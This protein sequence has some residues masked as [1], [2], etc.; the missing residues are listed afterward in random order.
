MAEISVGPP[1]DESEL[2][3]VANQRQRT[4]NQTPEQADDWVND[5]LSE[6]GNVRVVRKDGAVAGG[7]NL[8]PMGQWFGGRSVPMA[9]IGGVGIDP[10]HRAGGLASILM[11]SVVEELQTSGCALS[12]L[13]P[14]TVP[15]YRRVGYE[16]SGSFSRYSIRTN[17]I[18]IRERELD[19]TFVETPDAEMLA[20]LYTKRARLTS[21]NL[22]R[23]P[24]FWERV[25]NPPKTTLHTYVF[26]DEGYVT[27]T[28]PSGDGWGYD[29]ALRDIV[30]LT[31]RAARR[32]WTFFADHR[33]FTEKV[34]WVGTQADPLVFHLRE[35][36]WKL[37]DDWTWMLR[38]ID[39]ERALTERGYSGELE[40]EVSFE[41]ADDLLPA[42]NG[43]FTLH[44]SGGKGE[45][46]RNGNARTKLDVRGLASLYTGF[47][48]AETLR[49]TGYIEGPDEDLARLSAIFAG[50]APWLADFF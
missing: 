1:T 6:I 33:S 39:V 37:E 48:S 30:A 26:G 42:N 12:A 49:G 50:P 47:M 14:A 9:G 16:L 43:S 28:Q 20:D 10:Q 15:V 45:I 3:A 4:Y 18:D 8:I 36:D 31:P 19:V 24:W 35:Q 44:I 40:T 29:L 41:I 46:S 25:L 21:G 32:I 7:L 13:Y 27:F 5:R 11:R 2:R 17:T 23:S 22:D 38:V 34:K